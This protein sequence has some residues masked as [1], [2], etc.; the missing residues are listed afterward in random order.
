MKTICAECG[1]VVRAARLVFSR[2]S[3]IKTKDKDLTYLVSEHPMK[4]GK[5]ATQVVS[6]KDGR[7]S[8]EHCFGSLRPVRELIAVH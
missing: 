8:G 3:G 4:D 7:V 2:S 6:S 1:E 5:R